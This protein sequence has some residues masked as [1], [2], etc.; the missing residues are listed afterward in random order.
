MQMMQSVQISQ[1]TDL[2]TPNVIG[3]Q[4]GRVL[5]AKGRMGVSEATKRT[6]GTHGDGELE[7]ERQKDKKLL[8][9][10]SSS[11]PR[12]LECQRPGEASSVGKKCPDGGGD[13]ER[14]TP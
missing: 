10:G 9:E 14:M 7:M 4:G 5:S 1:L 8:R 6:T 3:A 13:R 12:P 2:I 11:P